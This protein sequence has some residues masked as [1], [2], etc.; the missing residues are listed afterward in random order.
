ADGT[1]AT[2]R[3]VGTLDERGAPSLAGVPIIGVPADAVAGY[4]AGAVTDRLD[5][6]VAPGASRAGT[7]EALRAALGADVQVHTR[8]AS[9][10]EATRQSSTLYGMVLIASLSFVLIAL[11]VARMVVGNTFTVVLAQRTRQLAL[12][13]C[14]GADRQQ[15]RRLIRRQGLL[16]GVGA[17]A[18]GVLLGVALGA[19][20]T[21]VVGGLDLGPVHLSLLPSPL[22]CLLAGPPIAFWPPM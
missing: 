12:L 22:T 6:R 7:V 21:A 17:S 20:G 4:A 3:L 13:R 8:E 16:L 18:T 15:L 14:V 11:A 2:A 5:V 19:A 1:T 10:N 9:V